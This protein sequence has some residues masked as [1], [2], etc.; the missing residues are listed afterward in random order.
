MLL[1]M[2]KQK[3]LEVPSEYEMICWFFFKL[4]VKPQRKTDVCPTDTLKTLHKDLTCICWPYHFSHDIKPSS[5]T[6]WFD[7]LR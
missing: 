3:E 7:V 1:R 5:F 4:G 6:A 2:F